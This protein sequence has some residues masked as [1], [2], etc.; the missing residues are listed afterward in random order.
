MFLFWTNHRHW[1]PTWLARGCTKTIF[2]FV[3]YLPL[4]WLCFFSAC[5]WLMSTRTLIFITSQWSVHRGLGCLHL[6][7]LFFA[8]WERQGLPL[9]SYHY[10]SLRV[11]HR[12]EK[13]EPSR[14]AHV[15]HKDTTQFRFQPSPELVNRGLSTAAWPGHQLQAPEGSLDSSGT[16][17]AA[18]GWAPGAQGARGMMVVDRVQGQLGRR[19]GPIQPS[20]SSRNEVT[21][22]SCWGFQKPQTFKGCSWK[23]SHT[24]AMPSSSQPRALQGKLLRAAHTRGGS[25]LN[26]LKE[27]PAGSGTHHPRRQCIPTAAGW[28]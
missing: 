9:C 6:G 16:L 26:P 1:L 11:L 12:E 23:W 22:R 3:S 28:S 21:V 2:V 25:L 5:S 27:A 17:G 8:N 4:S 10:Q 13:P 24:W 20:W 14:G 15:A 7:V 19:L 18:G